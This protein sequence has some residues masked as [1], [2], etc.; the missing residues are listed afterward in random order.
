LDGQGIEMMFD[1]NC[2]AKSA[3][4]RPRILS[5]SAAPQSA[6]LPRKSYKDR[7]G[8]R[9]TAAAATVGKNSGKRFA[10]KMAPVG[11]RGE[12]TTEPSMFTYLNFGGSTSRC[13]TERQ[14]RKLVFDYVPWS[15]LDR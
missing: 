12:S 15:L 9:G 11:G 4:P 3:Q 10:F 2:A 1:L 8:D 13:R 14:Q 6:P 5:Q 7:G